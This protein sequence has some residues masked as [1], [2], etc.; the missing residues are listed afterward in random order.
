MSKGKRT[1]RPKW[2]TTDPRPINRRP[3]PRLELDPETGL[4]P[5]GQTPVTPAEQIARARAKHHR[6]QRAR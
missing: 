5:V 2:G 3:A 6:R 1:N 4:P